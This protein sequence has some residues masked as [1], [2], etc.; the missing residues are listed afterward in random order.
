MLPMVAFELFDKPRRLRFDVNALSDLEEAMGTGIVTLLQEENLGF[1]AMR[2]FLWAGLKWED[3]GLTKERVG[4]MMT[5][6]LEEDGD[7][8]SLMSVVSRAI[9][10]SGLFRAPREGEGEKGG[11]AQEETV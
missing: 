10:A 9:A 1:R 8:A 3:R 11:N 5:K 6:Y 4:N 7:L 2:N